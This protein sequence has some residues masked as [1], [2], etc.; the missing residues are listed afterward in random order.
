[1]L[2]LKFKKIK[3]LRNYFFKN[4]KIKLIKILININI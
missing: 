4:I 1:M 3:L 2:N